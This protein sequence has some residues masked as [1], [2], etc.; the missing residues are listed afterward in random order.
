MAGDAVA[1]ST[2]TRSG[3]PRPTLKGLHNASV[4]KHLAIGIVWS[5]AAMIIAKI[6]VND[7][8]KEKYAEYYK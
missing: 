6:A 4:K 2:P 1:S 7:P 3:L 5:L 8:R